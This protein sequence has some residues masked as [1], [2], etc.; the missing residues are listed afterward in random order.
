MVVGVTPSIARDLREQTEAS[1]GA[2]AQFPQR[3]GLWEQGAGLRSQGGVC[4][5]H[6]YRERTEAKIPH[7]S[8]HLC[9]LDCG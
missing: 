6:L 5:M 8:H 9:K 4:C 1:S 3:D 7:T 2:P